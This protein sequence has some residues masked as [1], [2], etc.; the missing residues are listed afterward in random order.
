MKLIK[1]LPLAI[2]ILFSVSSIAQKLSEEKR[3]KMEKLKLAY[4]IV[5]LDLNEEKSAEFEDLY[6]AYQEER[7]NLRKEARETHQKMKDAN[8]EDT[9][10]IAKMSE[11]EAMQSLQ[12]RLKIEENKLAV[13]KKYMDKMVASIGAKKVLQLKKAEHEFKRELL[14]MYKDEKHRHHMEKELIEKRRT[15]QMEKRRN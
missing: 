11:K 15:E 7:K 14:H 9:D 2:M 10:Y 4:L 12:N 1:T 13:E 3:E 5:E 8:K 6:L